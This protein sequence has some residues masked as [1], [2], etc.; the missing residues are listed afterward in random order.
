MKILQGLFQKRNDST[1]DKSKRLDDDILDRYVLKE[2]TPQNIIDIFQGEWSSK[3]PDKYN[4]LTQPGTARLFEDSRVTWAKD[5]WGGFV[6]KAVLELGP[7][8]GGHTHMLLNLGATKVISIEANTR[9]FLKCLCIKEVLKLEGAE[10]KLGD[11]VLYLESC[12]SKFD[13]IWASGVLYHMIEPIKLIDLISRHSDRVFIWT[14]YYDSDVCSNRTELIEKFGPLE[15]GCYEGFLYGYSVYSYKESLNW[16]GFCGGPRPTSKWLT[17]NSIIE[18]LKHFGFQ[19]IRIGLD[20]ID[21]PNGP[22]FA[23]CASK[24]VSTPDL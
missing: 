11:F 19:D 21:H 9:S 4:L 23:I 2:P 13:I 5:I 16:A 1:T 20:E 7:L 24:G 12:E 6:D 15:K 3:L 10:F 14:H 22:A 8:E 18:A 17:R